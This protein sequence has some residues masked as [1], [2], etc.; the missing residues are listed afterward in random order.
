MSK[1]LMYQ[2]LRYLGVGVF[3]LVCGI[4]GWQ[5][6]AEL[7]AWQNLKVLLPQIVQ[8]LNAHEAVL[9]TQPASPAK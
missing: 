1:T 4:V 7:Q 2:G 3:C 6:R 5:L 9:K 8:L